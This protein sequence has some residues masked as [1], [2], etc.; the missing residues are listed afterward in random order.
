MGQIQPLYL[1]ALLKKEGQE[2]ENQSNILQALRQ[3]SVVKRYSM[4]AVEP[5]IF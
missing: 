4:R 2:K 1:N 5:M 3:K